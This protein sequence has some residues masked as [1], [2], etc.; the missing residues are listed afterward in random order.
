[1]EKLRAGNTSIRISG[2]FYEIPDVPL[3]K[4]PNNKDC[5]LSGIEKIG[6]DFNKKY[7]CTVKVID[8]DRYIT[9]NY[10]TIENALNNK[11][12]KKLLIYDKEYDI[13]IGYYNE[14]NEK[15][16]SINKFD[17]KSKKIFI[18]ECSKYEFKI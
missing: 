7:I 3:F 2:V 8:E 1:M 5:Y 16:K 6:N 13:P 14:I 15:Y 10:E 17:E 11:I 12:Y 18:N 4:S 9:I